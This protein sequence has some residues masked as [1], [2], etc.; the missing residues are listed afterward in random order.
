M[1][2]LQIMAR[3]DAEWEA[4]WEEQYD[5]EYYRDGDTRPA[6]RPVHTVATTTASV[7]AA[8][9]GE[10]PDPFAGEPAFFFPAVPAGSD[11]GAELPD[12]FADEPPAIVALLRAV[13][14]ARFE[15]DRETDFGTAD[16]R[17]LR[18]ALARAEADLAA[19]QTQPAA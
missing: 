17:P 15:L 4:Y 3:M 6:C 13:S 8:W 5:G 10:A 11:D 1:D 7:P 14:L 18:E 19:Y 16:L 12:P 9:D 2:E